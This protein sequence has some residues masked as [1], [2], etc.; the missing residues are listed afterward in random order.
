MKIQPSVTRMHITELFNLGVTRN[1][2]GELIKLTFNLRIPS[3]FVKLRPPNPSLKI[4]MI[5]SSLFHFHSASFVKLSYVES[6]IA[7]LQLAS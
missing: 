6:Q 1:L 5:G 7:S 2:T 3:T 4:S